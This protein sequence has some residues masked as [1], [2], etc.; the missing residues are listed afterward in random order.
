MQVSFCTQSLEVK[1]IGCGSFAQLWG[2]DTQEQM[3]GLEVGSSD[4]W[5]RNSLLASLEYRIVSK[6]GE[7]CLDPIQWG[8]T[9]RIWGLEGREGG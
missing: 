3:K 9:S 5:P 7:L 6:I 4:P 2:E 1:A 8:R